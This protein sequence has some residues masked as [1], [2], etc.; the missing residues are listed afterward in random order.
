M[1]LEKYNK[2][3]CDIC[4]MEDKKSPVMQVITTKIVEI[5][6]ISITTVDGIIL[7][8]TVLWVNDPNKII[9]NLKIERAEEYNK[10]FYE[11]L[12]EYKTFSSKRLFTTLTSEEDIVKA[13]QNKEKVRIFIDKKKYYVL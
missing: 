5:N 6:D 10:K 11:L 1:E 13:I 12:R 2:K 7:K 9:L 3:W 8:D 4:Y